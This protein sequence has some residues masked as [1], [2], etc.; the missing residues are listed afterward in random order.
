[1]MPNWLR[2]WR[3]A[4]LLLTAI[5][6]L[7]ASAATYLV[8][9]NG[10]Q[11]APYDTW[12]T[13]FSNIQDAVSAAAPDD[14]VLVTDGVYRVTGQIGIS[15][16][17][18]VQS[19]HGP[20]ATWVRGAYPLSTNRCFSLNGGARVDGFTIAGGYLA[21]GFGGGVQIGTNGTL[22]NCVVASN[23][24]SSGGGV[25]VLYGGEV[26]NCSILLNSFFDDGGGVYI[27]YTGTVQSCIIRGNYGVTTVGYRGGGVRTAAGANAVVRNCWIEGNRA[28]AGGGIYVNSGRIESCTV[29][30]NTGFSTGV[31]Y[32]GGGIDQ[33]GGIVRNT[34]AFNN[35]AQLTQTP[36]WYFGAGTAQYCCAYY[37]L[38]GVGNMTNHPRFRNE[39]AGDYRL[40]PGS[41][42]VDAGTNL[43]WMA[44]DTDLDGGSRLAGSAG[45]ADMGAYELQIGP[46]QC[47]LWTEP[48]QVLAPHSAVLSASVAG[49][50][51]DGLVF[52]WDLTN[53][54]TNDFAGSEFQ[55]VSA[56]Y[57][58][59]RHS[60]ALRVSNSAGET[61]AAT[62]AGFLK[63]G[64]A[65]AYAATNG[66]HVFPFTNL[67]T[68]ATNV[69]AAINAGVDGTLVLVSTGTFRGSLVITN[70][71]QVRSLGGPAAATLRSTSSYVVQMLGS[72]A[73]IGADPGAR[74]DGFTLT[75]ASGVP[76]AAMLAGG[77]TLRNCVITNFSTDSSTVT[78]SQNGSISDCLIADNLTAR[79]SPLIITSLMP[80]YTGSVDRCVIRNNRRRYYGVWGDSISGVVLN[81]GW[82]RNCLITDN[83]C[84]SN[85]CAGLQTSGGT[86]EN[87]TIAFNTTLSPN[88]DAVGG[89]FTTNA[90]I[91]RNCVVSFNT[92]GTTGSGAN[93]QRGSG[94]I[95]YTCTQPSAS[96][97]GAHNI[98]GDPLFVDAPGRNLRLRARSPCVD[99]GTNV[100][101]WMADGI[102]LAGLRRIM[103]GQVD[104]GAYETVPSLRSVS[105]TVR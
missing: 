14:L 57:P 50:N 37:P 91:V 1:M 32:V 20:A 17:V 59:G 23:Y 39:A 5:A 9:T 99:A 102:D 65:I 7:Q 53:D 89:I 64:P 58:E 93:Y 49:T 78:I 94:V 72:V 51:T 77:G 101:A 52:E 43:A 97:Y 62:R 104:A 36:N 47:D 103:A 83:L 34:I 63:V 44:A 16:T 41:P 87:C 35:N 85:A 22:L 74:L 18:T 55:S 25:H 4:A 56:P 2:A 27:Q 38:P 48:R 92:N 71:V 96:A 69:Q 13:A 90:A 31:G 21:A 80:G 19:V 54:G 3:L 46:L 67:L 40:A 61:A 75:P 70:G 73:N 10:S 26:R 45:A 68:A 98:D 15:R 12:E 33:L 30:N 6:G 8:W 88:A 82:A 76:L 29:V 81:G 66:S 28:R 24:A 84:V 86:V 42:C 79:G 95:E 11:I 105:I 100:P 60:V